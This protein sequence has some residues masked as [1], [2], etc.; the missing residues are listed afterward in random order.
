MRLRTPDQT[1]TVTLSD[2]SI[3]I[4]RRPRGGDLIRAHEL[5]PGEN[6]LKFACAMLSQLCTINGEP[7]VM[8]DIA[9][10]WASDIDKLSQEVAQIGDFLPSTAPSLP[11]SLNGAL[12]TPN[13][14][15]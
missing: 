15:K 13:L 5:A 6:R 9:E 2:G 11:S 7:C 4:L 14:R 10:L 8:E 12:D 1:K 3:V